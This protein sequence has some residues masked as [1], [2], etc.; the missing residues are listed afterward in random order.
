MPETGVSERCMAGHEWEVILA[1]AGA[2]QALTVGIIRYLLKEVEKRDQRIEKMTESA[3]AQNKLN[4]QMAQLYVAQ[5]Q[6]RR[7]GGGP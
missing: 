3:L 4:E 6:Q 5:E 2:L 7:S 1:L